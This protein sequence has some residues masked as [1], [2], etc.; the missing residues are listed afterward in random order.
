MY[1]SFLTKIFSLLAGNP[2]TSLYFP[3]PVKYGLVLSIFYVPV[4]YI[5]KEQLTLRSFG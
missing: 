2:P 1:L 3:M 4:I 5:S